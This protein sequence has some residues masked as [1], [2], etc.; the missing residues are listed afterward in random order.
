MAA[1]DPADMIQCIIILQVSETTMVTQSSPA[2]PPPNFPPNTPANIQNALSS[3]GGG[4]YTY[5]VPE[6]TIVEVPQTGHYNRTL[7]SRL[8]P[9]MDGQN[10][11]S[12][13]TKIFFNDG[14]SIMIV[15]SLAST[16]SDITT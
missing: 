5:D 10:V 12:G 6:T 13:R 16:L 4:A 9:V 15:G 1:I 7:V 3:M 14:T 11:V 8:E 2:P